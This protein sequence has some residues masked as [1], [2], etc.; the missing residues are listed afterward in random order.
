MRQTRRLRVYVLNSQALARLWQSPTEPWCCAPAAAEEAQTKVPELS[1]K[2]ARLELKHAAA[3]LVK[4]LLRP[5]YE[6]RKLDHP[7]FKSIAKAAVHQL[8]CLS[9]DNW[10]PAHTV[11]AQIQEM[12]RLTDEDLRAAGLPASAEMIDLSGYS[13]GMLTSLTSQ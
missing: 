13:T 9:R 7:T 6:D 4:P 2:A 11:A 1:I 10:R 5:L 3:G 8:C 12:T